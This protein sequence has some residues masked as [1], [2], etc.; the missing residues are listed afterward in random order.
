MGSVTIWKHVN[1]R[2]RTQSDAKPDVF[3]ESG[4]TVVGSVFLLFRLFRA[5]SCESC[6]RKVRTSVAARFALQNVKKLTTPEHFSKMWSAKNAQ[7]CGESS[8]CTSTCLKTDGLASLLEEEVGKM[9]ICTSKI[10]KLGCCFILSFHW[11]SALLNHWFIDSVI[12]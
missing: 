6:R 11:F 9:C 12:H 7:D 10:F 8:A 3:R 5:S 2:V 4:V 1:S